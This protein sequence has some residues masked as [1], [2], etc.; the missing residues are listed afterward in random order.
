[1]YDGAEPRSLVDY[2]WLRI[3]LPRDVAPGDRVRVNARLPG[4][5][6]PGDY[7]IVFDLV[8]EGVLWFADRGSLTLEVPCRVA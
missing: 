6:R 2:D 8:I 1:L 3:A 7:V 4:I 5:H